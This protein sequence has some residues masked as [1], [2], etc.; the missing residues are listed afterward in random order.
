MHSS[1]SSHTCADSTMPQS[2]SVCNIALSR[3]PE[4]CYSTRSDSTT[5]CAAS[6]MP[7]SPCASKLPHRPPKPTARTPTNTGREPDQLLTHGLQVKILEHSTEELE[8]AQSPLRRH[9]RTGQADKKKVKK[10]EKVILE[11]Q[12]ASSYQRHLH[13]QPTLILNDQ[14]EPALNDHH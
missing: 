3:S 9:S 6:I 4:A 2:P 1:C 14:C 12:A 7:H 10:L 8:A 13:Q 5:A 11:L